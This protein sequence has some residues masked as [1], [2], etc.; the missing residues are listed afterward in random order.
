[1][2]RGGR[3]PKPVKCRLSEEIRTWLPPDEADEVHRTA[4]RL[5]LSTAEYVRRKLGFPAY[6]SEYEPN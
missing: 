3:P 2:N 4:F 5:G 1:V 6:E